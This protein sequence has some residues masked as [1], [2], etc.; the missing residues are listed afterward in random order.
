VNKT[1][2]NLHK[3]RLVRGNH[4]NNEEYSAV[5]GSTWDNSEGYHGPF[6]SST[7]HLMVQARTE[8]ELTVDESDWESSDVPDVEF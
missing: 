1:W 8:D 7:S 4:K 3:D 6:K 2:K 5:A